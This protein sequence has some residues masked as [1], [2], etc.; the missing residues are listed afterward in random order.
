MRCEHWSHYTLL[1]RCVAEAAV[2]AQRLP[3]ALELL[4]RGMRFQERFGPRGIA[5]GR[6]YEVRAQLAISM[7]D[8]A[9]LQHYFNLCAEQFANRRDGAV[10]RKYERL[11]EE[12]SV[13]GLTLTPPA[14]A[15]IAG[16]PGKQRAPR[17][18]QLLESS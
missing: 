5:L 12:A 17:I 2:T 1:L 3:E 8:Q 16:T 15:P 14:R 6:L 7:H 9:A 11:S 4:E 18:A 13:V 10:S